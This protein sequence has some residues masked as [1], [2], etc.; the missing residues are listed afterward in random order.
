METQAGRLR[1]TLVPTT[2]PPRPSLACLPSASASSR[3]P[4]DPPWDHDSPSLLFVKLI[5]PVPA[6]LVLLS[7]TNDQPAH[8]S[9]IHQS[10][11]P[12]PISCS[13]T[14]SDAAQF[15]QTETGRIPTT[16]VP[17]CEWPSLL[18]QSASSSG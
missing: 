7:V 13:L 10:I 15:H 9:V 5:I 12:S 2:F 16:P 18:D 3:L 4:L 17:L 14:P 8:C 11:T 6:P 1:N